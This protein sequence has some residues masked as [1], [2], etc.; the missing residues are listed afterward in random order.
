MLMQPSQSAPP[1]PPPMQPSGTP[2]SNP[3]DFIMNENAKPK[4]NLFPKG[5]SKNQRILIFGI[6]IALFFLL[7]IVLYSVLTAS[8][9]AGT[10]DM[11]NAAQQQQ[12][13]ARI[14]DIGIEKAKETDTKNTAII[15]AETI[16]S[17]QVA[18]VAYL[19]KNG[20]KLS[21]KELSITRNGQTDTSLTEAE[22]INQFDS[23]FTSTLAKQVSKYQSTLKDAH[24]HT[25]S[26]AGKKILERMYNNAGS[27]GAKLQ[28]TDT[29]N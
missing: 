15:T 20:K 8:S 29:N 4:R 13:I 2:P 3:Y 7:G 9:S 17:D 24:D 5:N 18:L 21:V 27:L 6:G 28:S 14:A 16:R 19:N 1:A 25:S 10:T 11:V 22:Q 26:N 12:E 23:T